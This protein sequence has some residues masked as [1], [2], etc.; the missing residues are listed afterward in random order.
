MRI[1]IITVGKA[2]DEKLRAAITEYEKRISKY[3]KISWD[4][5]PVSNLNTES[6]QILG[7]LGGSYAILL[8]EH[9]TQLSTP[10]VA[11]KIETLQNNSAKEVVFII[12]GAYGI[13]DEVKAEA[14]FVWSLS[15][16][17]F[18]HQLVRLILIEQ[19]YR[20]FDVL[21]GGNYHHS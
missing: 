13:N 14:D 12:G 19:L 1:R 5:V 9:G 18:P 2:H 17:V 6:N 11:A 15:P 3:S 8:D 21:N 16:L 10:E 20:A 7:R 4:I